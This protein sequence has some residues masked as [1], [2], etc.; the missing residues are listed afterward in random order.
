MLSL[1]L[2]CTWE[3]LANVSNAD[4]TKHIRGETVGPDTTLFTSPFFS[5]ITFYFSHH[6][7]SQSS[8]KIRR[9]SLRLL[10]DLLLKVQSHLMGYEVASRLLVS[11]T[12]IPLNRCPCSATACIADLTHSDA[13]RA[14]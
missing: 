13:Q 10:N 2:T 11:I 3:T 4:Y 14:T 12:R 6:D 7:F 9:H 1:G 5:I 8:L